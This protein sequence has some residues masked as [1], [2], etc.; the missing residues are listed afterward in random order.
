MHRLDA[1]EEGEGPR[2]RGVGDPASGRE[3]LDRVLGRVAALV[4]REVEPGQG[5]DAHSAQTAS[6]ARQLS[7][8][9][10][11]G[12]VTREAIVAP[13]TRPVP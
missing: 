3:A 10:L 11:V 2:G 1:E 8:A 13:I 4:R 12:A 6:A 5:Q 7:V 9:S